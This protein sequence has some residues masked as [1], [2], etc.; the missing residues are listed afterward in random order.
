MIYGY[1]RVSTYTQ[2]ADGNGLAAQ[3]AALEAAGATSIFEESFT[4][5]ANNRPELQKLL[6]KLVDGDTIVVTKLDR[7][8]RSARKGLEL[9]DELN[10]KNIKVQILNMGIIDNTSVGKSLRKMMLGFAEFERDLIVEKTQE[11]K[12]IARKN[13]GFREGR[14]QKFT[15]VQ[16]KHA[17]E[18]LKDHS[19]NQVS[20]ITGISVSTIK[21]KKNAYKNDQ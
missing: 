14:P 13:P 17:L 18:L 7:I 20:K 21:R 5:T 11:G 12:R 9:I 15:E 16:I 19:Y 10:A 1:A 8:A 2:A 6:E 4:G 3:R